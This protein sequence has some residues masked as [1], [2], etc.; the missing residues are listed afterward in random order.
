M[1][2]IAGIYGALGEADVAP[3]IAALAHRG[4]DGEGAW[5]SA[6]HGVALGHRRLSIIDIGEG[7]AQPMRGATGT[8]VITYNGEIYN[9]RELRLELEAKGARFATASDT[10]VLLALLDREGAAALPRI[11]GMFAF[12][13]LDEP[14]GDLLVA[15]DAFGV[16]PLYYVESGG[17]F[18]FASEIRA[19]RAMAAADFSPQLCALHR[20]M[21]FLWNP[22]DEAILAPVRKLAPGEALIV[23]Q[24]RVA[25]RWLWHNGRAAFASKRPAHAG[26]LAA[27]TRERLRL[28]VHRQMVAD[29]PVGAFLS[30]GLDSSAVVAFARESVPDL[31]CF[32]IDTGLDDLDGNVSDLPY[33]KRV[34]AHLGVPLHIVEVSEDRLIAD[35]ELMV[36]RLE[37]PVADPASLNTLYISELARSM[38]L[39]VLLSGTGGDDI[40]TGYRRHRLARYNFAFEAVPRRLRAAAAGIAERLDQRRTMNRKLAKALSGVAG[41]RNGRIVAQFA[42][43]DQSVLAPLYT[44]EFRSRIS[45]CA[46]TDILLDYLSDM[47]PGVSDV[48]RMLALEQRYFLADHNLIYTDKMAMTAGIEVRVPFLDPDLAA[49]AATLPDAVRQNARDAKLI[50]KRAMEPLLP[51]DVVYRPKT[52]FGAP[53]RRWIRNELRDYVAER[54]APRELDRFGVFEPMAVAALIESNQSG[55]VDA[56]YTILSLLCAQLWL[57]RQSGAEAAIAK[58]QVAA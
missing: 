44:A 41:D 7:G 42:W 19:L 33:A 18:F 49:F 4:P 14:S 45:A 26:D 5:F 3:G 39:K 31:P 21:T 50:F 25:E 52:G 36:D 46:T 29:V 16:K 17:R 12:G 10:E 53:V 8:S 54:L 13:Y 35:L 2:G 56:G 32:T 34:A 27:E 43:A 55:E 6:A 38:G 30:G 23:R 47:P 57:A 40:F 51:H 22:G 15:R 11:N 48:D 1:C 24:G 37:E 58:R 28:A 9:Y 20:H